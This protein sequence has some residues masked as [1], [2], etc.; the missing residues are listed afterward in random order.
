MI[1]SLIFAAFVAGSSA[2]VAD[3]LLKDPTGAQLVGQ[4]QFGE[5]TVNTTNNEQREKLDIGAGACLRGPVTFFDANHAV[6]FEL[7]P[8]A[9]YPLGCDK[10]DRR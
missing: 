5:I 8:G 6:V 4:V 2:A 3:P 10:E 1:R 7:A 9:M